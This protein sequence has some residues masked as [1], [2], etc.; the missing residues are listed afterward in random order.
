MVVKDG[1]KI[2]SHATKTESMSQVYMHM[3]IVQDGLGTVVIWNLMM[4]GVK[5]S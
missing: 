3:S 5:I 2:V 4:K 1:R